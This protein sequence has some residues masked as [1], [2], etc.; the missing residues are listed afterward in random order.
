MEPEGFK[1]LPF[2]KY[3]KVQEWE[4]RFI[5]ALNTAENIDYIEKCFEQKLNTIK[6]LAKNSVDP[7][8]HLS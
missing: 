3:Y 5:L 6:F 7:Y 1:N 2:L 4:S 8:L